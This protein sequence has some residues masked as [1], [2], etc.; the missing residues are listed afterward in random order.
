MTSS[1][2]LFSLFSLLF[3]SPF[4]EPIYKGDSDSS[5]DSRL[6]PPVLS[7]SSSNDSEEDD[8]DERAE[9]VSHGDS[10]STV[11]GSKDD[12]NAGVGFFLT[13]FDHRNPADFNDDQKNRKAR[14]PGRLAQGDDDEDGDGK[15]DGAAQMYEEGEAEA[16]Y[17]D[18]VKLQV[19]L[20][21]HL[22]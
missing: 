21:L 18:C 7:S 5:D 10:D 15:G 1:F 9:R 19:C 12:E 2:P 11:N 3:S 13:E 22:S 14:K 17:N 20:C 6:G 8:D 16:R 4:H